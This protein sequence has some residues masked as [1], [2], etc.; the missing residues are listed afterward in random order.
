MVSKKLSAAVD[1]TTSAFASFLFALPSYM[2]ALVILWLLGFEH[3]QIQPLF[4]LYVGARALSDTF[5][6][7]SKMHALSHAELSTVISITALHPIFMIVV[8]PLITND[9]I[10]PRMMLGLLLSVSGTLIITFKQAEKRSSRKGILYALICALFFSINS[11]LDRVTVQSASP[12][13][14]GFIM[15]GIACLFLIPPLLRSG[16]VRDL[17]THAPS[18]LL[19]GLFETLFMMF[20]LTALTYL[21]APELSA[22]TRLSV[23]FSVIGGNIVFKEVDLKRK[24]IGG[25]LT[26]AGVVTVLL[27]HAA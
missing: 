20:K 13:L 27:G 23:L 10:T 26:V 16:K 6:E 3:F 8:S 7:T 24:L 14:S 9:P 25:F 4:W 2:I 12:T 21:T 19:R 17:S 1:G 15:A 18:F 11:S 22:I 5:A